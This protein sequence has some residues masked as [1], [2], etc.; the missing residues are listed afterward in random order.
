MTL[1]QLE[2]VKALDTYRHFVTAAEK[3]FVTQPTITLQ[4]KKLEEEIGFQLFDRSKTP[5]EPTEMGKLV[6]SKA[7]NI[8][9]EMNQLKELVNSERDDIKGSFKIGVIPTVS[10]Y[11]VPKFLGG[12]INENPETSLFIDEMKSEEI[13]DSIKSNKIDIGIMVTPI[14]ENSIREIPLY[15]EPFVFYGELNN[16]N[17]TISIEEIEHKKGLWLL[18]SGHCFGNQVLSICKSNEEGNQIQFKSGSIETLMK[19]VDEY[20]GFTLIPELVSLNTDQKKTRKFTLPQ[21]IREVS[22]VV[23]KG[24][25]KENLINALR[26]EILSVI[27]KSFEKNDRFIKVKWR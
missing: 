4:V 22:I 16:T 15:N 23:H 6:I 7:R 10:P 24:F 19:M 2:Y 3:C 1:Q 9:M 20:G 8:L 11:I 13:I 5:L 12:F 21:P 26:K 27:P 14:N 17:D 18:S 25:V